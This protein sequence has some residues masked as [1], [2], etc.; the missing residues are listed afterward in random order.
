MPQEEIQFVVLGIM[1]IRSNEENKKCISLKVKVSFWRGVLR[2]CNS[3]PLPICD[4]TQTVYNEYSNYVLGQL[5]LISL[6]VGRGVSELNQTQFL[7][8]R[9]EP[10]TSLTFVISAIS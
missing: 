9:M 5:K 2:G 4:G 10:I 7:P 8:S 1:R 3:I 6:L